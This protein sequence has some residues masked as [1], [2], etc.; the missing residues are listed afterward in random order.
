M[1][2]SLFKWIVNTFDRWMIWT[3]IIQYPM[4][5]RRDHQYHVEMVGQFW[6]LTILFGKSLHHLSCA[7]VQFWDS[8][9]QSVIRRM[10][11]KIRPTFEDFSIVVYFVHSL[12]GV[13]INPNFVWIFG[14]SDYFRWKRF[15]LKQWYENKFLVLVI[16]FFPAYR[17]FGN[18]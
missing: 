4:A 16:L 10:T 18:M 9:K 15:H 11:G 14:S 12:C 5:L 6:H 8:R 17:H 3:S 7:I 1:F 13:L 2:I